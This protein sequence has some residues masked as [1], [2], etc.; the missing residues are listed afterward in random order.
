MYVCAATRAEQENRP[1]P[2]P[3]ANRMLDC[4]F[5]VIGCPIKRYFYRKQRVSFV[6]DEVR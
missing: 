5:G 6:W 3:R 1:K 2:T 4:N